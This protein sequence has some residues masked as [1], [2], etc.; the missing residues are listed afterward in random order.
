MQATTNRRK[1]IYTKRI[2][3]VA[4]RE[5]ETQRKLERTD[6]ETNTENVGR[7]IQR[8]TQRIRKKIDGEGKR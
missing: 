5:T 8:E 6:R 7:S 2:L 3:E 4:E 1:G